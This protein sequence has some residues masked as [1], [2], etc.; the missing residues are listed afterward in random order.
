MKTHMV[1]IEFARKYGIKEGLILTELCRRAYSSGVN[2]VPFSVS[3]GKAFFPY[4]SEKQIRLA[5]DNLKAAGCVAKAY[6]SPSVDRTNN[7]SV[8]KAVC[9]FYANVMTDHQLM[10]PG[11][12]QPRSGGR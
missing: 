7:Y 1:V 3:Q 6:S 10:L 12:D 4:M 8:Q 5:L 2:A 9:Q 11:N